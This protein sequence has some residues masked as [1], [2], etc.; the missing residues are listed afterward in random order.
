MALGCFVPG[1]NDAVNYF[2]VGAVHVPLAVGL[3]LMMYPPL[4]KVKYEGL[5]KVF[6]NTRII[7]LS[8]FLNWVLGPLLMFLLAIWLL[9][10]KTGYMMGS[11]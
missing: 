9:P 8:L 5:P 3:I 2:S 6:K 4:A 1:V 7:G 11:F 10:D